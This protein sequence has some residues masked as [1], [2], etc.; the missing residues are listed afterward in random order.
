MWTRFVQSKRLPTDE[1]LSGP[2]HIQKCPDVDFSALTDMYI[3]LIKMVFDHHQKK[4][5]IKKKVQPRHLWSQD[6]YFYVSQC[7]ARFLLII[8]DPLESNWR[9]HTHTYAGQ[10]G[11]GTFSF[12]SKISSLQLHSTLIW[13]PQHIE[14]ERRRES[15]RNW[16]W[17]DRHNVVTNSHKRTLS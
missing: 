12:A 2:E 5:I 11:V 15:S 8:F 3:S 7:E 4:E 14:W 9:T 13:A 10:K 6:R 16:Q 1:S 17:T